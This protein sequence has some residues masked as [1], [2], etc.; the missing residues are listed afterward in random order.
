MSKRTVERQT[1]NRKKSIDPKG[2]STEGDICVWTFRNIDKAGKF[3]FNPHRQDFDT[4]DFLAK[5]LSYSQMTWREIKKQ[6]HDM[7]KSKNHELDAASLS[8]EAKS[9]VSAKNLEEYADRLFSFALNNKVRVIGV[10]L[11]AEFQVVWYDPNH[12]FA[13]SNKKHT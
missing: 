13:P 5:M 1:P 10:R 4:K 7:N 2:F 11:G 3:A 6:T 8:S 9:R 12:E